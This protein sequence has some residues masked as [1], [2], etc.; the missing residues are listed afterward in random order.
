MVLKVYPYGV[1]QAQAKSAIYVGPSSMSIVRAA[2]RLMELMSQ[3]GEADLIAPLVIDEILIRLLRSPIGSRVAQV[4]I[5]E[6]SVHK[7]AQA[8]DWLRANYTEPMN[9]EGLAKLV[10]M[11]VSSFHQHFKAVTSIS[12]LQYQKVLRLQAAR[13]LMAATLMDAGTAGRQVGYVSAS[14]FSREYS[15]YFGCAPTKDIAKLRGHNLAAEG[16]R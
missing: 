2:V 10:N 12:P 13:R 6:S 5:A 7:I 16:A 8:V 14:Q 1:P 11:S 4:G 15:R 9:V 3:P